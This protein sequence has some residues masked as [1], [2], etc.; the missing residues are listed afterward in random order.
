MTYSSA[1]NRTPKSRV[2]RRWLKSGA[3]RTTWRSIIRKVG[4][5]R[6]ERID[7]LLCPSSKKSMDF[8]SSNRMITLDWESMMPFDWISNSKRRKNW[9][10][11]YKMSRDWST[12]ISYQK[13]YVTP[14]GI[15]SSRVRHGI[16]L[17]SRQDTV[18]P[19]VNG[20]TH[21]STEASRCYSTSE[22]IRT[23]AKCWKSAFDKP[24]GY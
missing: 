8:Q 21:S 12:P 14:S 19:F 11:V 4:S 17:L 2:P 13:K 22:E 9:N 1:P 3:K 20:A 23:N 5:C 7:E 16:S 15:N 18:K 24:M 6:S 10:T